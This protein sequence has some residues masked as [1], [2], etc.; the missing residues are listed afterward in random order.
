MMRLV[1]N[2]W[3][4]LNL[5]V[6]PPLE[7][8]RALPFVVKPCF[9]IFQESQRVRPRIAALVIPRLVNV[10]MTDTP[11]VWSFTPC[12]WAPTTGRPRPP[13]RPA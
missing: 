6:G 4:S 7:T 12:A 2:R 11:V 1:L 10:P 9:V 13:S 8:S 3:P 5:A